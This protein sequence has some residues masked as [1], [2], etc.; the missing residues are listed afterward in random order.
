MLPVL[1]VERSLFGLQPNAMTAL[2]EPPKTLERVAGYDPAY[3]RW[4]RRALPIELHPP[5]CQAVN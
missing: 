1:P 5:G 2:A 4:R 3:R